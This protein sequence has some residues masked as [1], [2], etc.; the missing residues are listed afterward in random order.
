MADL[1]HNISI[2]KLKLNVNGLN[3]PT[4]RYRLTEQIR[5]KQKQK[6]PTICYLHEKKLQMQP[7]LADSKKIKIYQANI[8]FK[9]PGKAILISNQ[10]HNFF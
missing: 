9:H 4:K 3:K 6:Q 7:R 8:D 5:N 10:Q 2:V 1:C